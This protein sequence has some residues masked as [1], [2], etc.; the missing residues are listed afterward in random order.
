METRNLKNG[1]LSLLGFGLMRLPVKG[2]Y[3]EVDVAQGITM[4]DYALS[5]GVNYFDTAWM[6]HNGKAEYF[7]GEALSRHERSG[8]Y[9]ADKM[10]LMS[11]TAEADVDR[12]FKEQLK[13]CRTPYF[14]FYL[15]HNIN[16]A[17]IKTAESFK[18]YEKLKEKQKQGLITYLGFSFHD[19]PELLQAVVDRYD[20][21]FAQIQLN[22]VDWELQQAEKLYRILEQQ[23][24]PVHIM[25]PV[26]GGS[27]A[28][29]PEEVGLIFKTA[30]PQASP[31]SWALRYAASLPGVQV[32]LSG[33]S[34]LEQ[35]QDNVKTMSPFKPLTPEERAVIE[36]AL[37]AYRKAATIPCTNCR[38]CMDCPQGVEIPKNLGIYNN[39]QRAISQSNPMANFL[40][41]MEYR[42]FKEAE[43][44]SNCI[45]CGDCKTRCPQHIDI[46][47]WIN[48]ITELHQQCLKPN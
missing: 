38:Y 37:A 45:G 39:Y 28:N 25:E 16:Q 33:M 24:I 20:W 48:V 26:R 40:F 13:K 8:F 11:L 22:Y 1:N 6:Y 4:V 30:A 46:P 5:K 31:A 34:T 35:V 42:L 19:R 23:S 21:D 36:T 27:L 32:V 47:H 17:H 10:P 15:L 41:E 2:E 3:G 14:D 29:L 12:I 18:V 43:Q 7:A 44:A 9:L